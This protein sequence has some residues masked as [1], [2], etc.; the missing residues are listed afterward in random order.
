MCSIIMSVIKLILQPLIDVLH[1]KMF[2]QFVFLE[3][4]SIEYANVSRGQNGNHDQITTQRLPVINLYFRNKTNAFYYNEITILLTLQ[5]HL[6]PRDPVECICKNFREYSFRKFILIKTSDGVA[7]TLY[8][9]HVQFVLTEYDIE[10]FKYVKNISMSIHRTKIKTNQK[11]ILLNKFWFNGKL[12]QLKEEI[13]K[14]NIKKQEFV[15][16]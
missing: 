6:S 1:E 13:K 3:D 16:I 4:F 11:M 2:E 10:T 12:K 8:P 5:D 7:S 15:N 9:A 14:F